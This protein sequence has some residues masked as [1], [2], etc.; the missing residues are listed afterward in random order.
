[1]ID[2]LIV[3]LQA[4][5]PLFV[6][7]AVGYVIRRAGLVDEYSL[8][9]MNAVCFKVFMASLMFNNIY[10]VDLSVFTESGV[11]IYILVAVVLCLIGVLILV[12]LTEK[13]RSKRGV[14]VQAMFR[15]NFVVMGLPLVVN[16]YGQEGA[17]IPSILIAIVVPFFNISCVILLTYF[18]GK[19]RPTLK[20]LLKKIFTNPY[21]VA[22]LIAFFLKIIHLEL[23]AMVRS[24]VKDMAN[25]A[26]PLALLILGA[27]FSF[28]NM[29]KYKK[30]LI[31]CCVMR[32]VVV[33][34]VFVLPAIWMG[35]RGVSLMTCLAVFATPTAISS[36][37]M[38]QE[39]G[40]DADLC[41]AEVVMSTALSIL[42]LF[43]WIFCFKTLGLLP[44]A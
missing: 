6:M 1:M 26:N 43:L 12:N 40:G 44:A 38:T 14:L 10:T 15:A 34:F 37:V 42:T 41:G 35:F 30:D 28:S 13:D 31:Y 39:L 23:P 33:P 9:K 3:S 27:S 32:L 20:M 22:A 7:M 4:V 11:I 29:P 24:V 21:I 19:E 5:F 18:N 25:V 16:L 17:A 36:H 8:K 2:N